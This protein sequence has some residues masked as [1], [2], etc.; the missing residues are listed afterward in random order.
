MNKGNKAT[1]T[2][3]LIAV[4][5][6]IIVLLLLVMLGELKSQNGSGDTAASK[7]EE[8]GS[9]TADNQNWKTDIKEFTIKTDSGE[10][11]KLHTPENYY[12][13]TDQYL[14]NLKG[15][16]GV[17]EVASDNMVVVGDA[18][19]PYEAKTV[20]NANT[21]SDTRNMLKQLYGD[22]FKEDE[23]IDAEAYTYMKTGKLPDTLP[24]N[25]K[26]DELKT[27]EVNGVEFVVYEVNYDT[28][29]QT[30]EN[31]TADTTGET[32]IEGSIGDEKAKEDG[33]S[34][35]DEEESEDKGNVETVH[36]QQ[37]SCYSKT[38]D[39]VEIILYQTEFNKEE[40]LK[41]LESFLG[42]EQK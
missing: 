14:D 24:L 8:D 13:L 23:V 5:G 36:T 41:T 17:D 15:Y 2:N 35:K 7:S 6:T 29:Y 38:D 9:S 16:Y 42:V 4:F 12:S 32:P 18:A 34:D 1:T 37:L 27:Y 30:E 3:M 33:E 28:E 20:I 19:G 25:Y 26:I 31:Q 11:I 21:L 39:A 10:E 40:A 22:E